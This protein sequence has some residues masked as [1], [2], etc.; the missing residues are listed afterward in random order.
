VTLAGIALFGE[1][2]DALTVVG[3]VVIF[4]ATVYLA[5]RERQL[6]RAALAVEAGQ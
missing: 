1:R 2:F 6:A 5:V 4:S 3:G